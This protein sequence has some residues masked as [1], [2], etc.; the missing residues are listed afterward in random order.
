MLLNSMVKTRCRSC[1]DRCHVVPA[2]AVGL[3]QIVR[4][5]TRRADETWTKFGF[6]LVKNR[7]LAKKKTANQLNNAC[8]MMD[9]CSGKAA[10]AASRVCLMV[11]RAS[12]KV[13]K[14]WVHGTKKIGLLGIS[15]FEWGGGI[16]FAVHRIVRGL[17]WPCASWAKINSACFV[18]HALPS[19]G[20]AYSVQRH[21]HTEPVV[22]AP[23][24]THKMPK[25]FGKSPCR[26]LLFPVLVVP[27]CKSMTTTRKSHWMFLEISSKT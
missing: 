8:L 15:V 19:G 1:Q 24:T 27:R 12:H 10:R 4:N 13:L 21:C 16:P 11:S 22:A 2:Q 26:Q 23:P 14:G 20:A 9:G 6:L 5:L 18:R 17:L 3:P 25:L 7:Y